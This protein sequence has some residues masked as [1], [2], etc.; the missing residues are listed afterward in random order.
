MKFIYKQNCKKI[1]T[2]VN[3]INK[4]FMIFSLKIEKNFKL[5]I[6]KSFLK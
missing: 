6:L 1:I 5:Y 2:V 4:P 3:I